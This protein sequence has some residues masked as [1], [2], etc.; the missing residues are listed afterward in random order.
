MD[1]SGITLDTATALSVA[2]IV[3]VGL[4]VLWGA[5]AALGFIR[6]G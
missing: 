1:T 5:K 6:R 3:A 2:A 4:G